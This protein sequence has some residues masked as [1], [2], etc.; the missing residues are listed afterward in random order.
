MEDKMFGTKTFE[1]R[2]DA[3]ENQRC[4]CF[5]D[6]PIRKG[7]V[8]CVHKKNFLKEVKNREESEKESSPDEE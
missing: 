6:N 3:E 8:G 4:G 1:E 5:P 7:C 2:Q